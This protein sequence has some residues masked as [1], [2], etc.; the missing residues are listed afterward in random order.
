ME[1]IKAE[2]EKNAQ[3][4]PVAKKFVPLLKVGG[5]GLSSLVKGDGTKT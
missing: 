1:R 3:N 4:Q 5:L 2:K